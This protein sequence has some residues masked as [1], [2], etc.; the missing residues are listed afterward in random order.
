MK[1]TVNNY[2]YEAV[3][4]V[5]PGGEEYVRIPTKLPLEG[6]NIVI[7]SSVKSSKEIMQLLMLTDALRSYAHKDAIFTLDLGYLPYARQDR[8]CTEGESFSLKVFCNLI[9]SLNFDKVLVTDCHSEIGLVLLNNI[10]HTSQL[11]GILQSPDVYNMIGDCDVVVAPDLG[12]NK[13]ASEVAKYFNKPLIQCLKTRE[14]GKISV[15]VLDDITDMIAVVVDD[16]CDGG[17][18]FLALAESLRDYEPKELNL[19]VTHGIFSKGKNVLL[20]HYDN[21]KAYKDWS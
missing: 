20:D 21:V 13:K 18:T 14:N 15:R 7:N 4:S 12:A 5:F 19:Y 11:K 16:I 6:M 8:V 1:F 2:K 3:T 9:N 17:G 10:V